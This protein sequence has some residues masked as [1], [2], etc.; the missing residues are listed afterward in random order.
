MRA[1]CSTRKN[2]RIFRL[3]RPDLNVRILCFE[4]LPDTGDCSTGSDPRTETIDL[5]RNLLHDLQSGMIFVCLHIVDIGK[6]LRH[7][8][9][10]IFLLHAQRRLQALINAGTDIS[11]VVDQ[12]DI[13]S[14]VAH[15]FSA[16]LTHGIRHDDHRMI[17]ADRSDQ[18]QTD[19]LITTCWLNDNRVFLD[20]SFPLC[21]KNHLVRCT[22]LDRSA[23]IDSFKFH[24]NIR[25]VLIHHA[26]QLYH[27]RVSHCF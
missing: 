21:C 10:R 14:I 20:Q 3:N 5:S 4:H 6:L 27:R 1:D 26:L 2:R 15:K 12:F 22:G 17:T 9:T 18:C 19:S 11:G 16:F 13:R 24:I 25:T 23:D 7:K 8:D